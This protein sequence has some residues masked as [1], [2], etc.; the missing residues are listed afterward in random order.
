[1]KN[2]DISNDLQELR[3]CLDALDGNILQL[4]KQRTDLI[5][6]VAALKYRSSANPVF[7]RHEREADML[8]R[9]V[10]SNESALSDADIRHIFREIISA[11]RGLENRIGVAFLGPTGT[12]TEQALMN[13]FGQ[14]AQVDKYAQ[15]TIDQ[16]FDEVEK[17]RCQYGIVPIENSFEGSVNQTLDA[18]LHQC[19]KVQIVAETCLL[20]EHNLISRCD[21]LQQL[22]ILFTHEQ[23]LSQCRQWIDAQQLSWRID[24]VSS[25]SEA[26]RLASETPNSAAIA[27]KQAALN[28]RLPIRFMNIQTSSNNVTR[29]FVIATHDVQPAKIN[30]TSI[31]FSVNH[32]PGSLS[33]ALQVLADNQV[34][35]SKLQSRPARDDNWQYLFYVE[36][37][38]HVQDAAI[39]RSLRD[40]SP[41]T[42]MLKVLGS[43]PKN[44]EIG[45][46]SR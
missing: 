4:L 15:K 20:I 40:I 27:S 31:M 8:N 3:C 24:C 39:M 17:G 11:C 10:D 41:F 34:N 19:Q 33:K 7:M 26:A 12:Y 1:M 46:R 6:Q 9:L 29:F 5:Q 36:L 44:I 16:V 21:D 42:Q 14:S 23:T 32:Q 37:D 28:Y 38:G 35:M 22:E 2:S 43:Y 30:Q 25:N 13:Y 45:H 18:L